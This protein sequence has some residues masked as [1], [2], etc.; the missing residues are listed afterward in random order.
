MLTEDRELSY[1]D[2]QRL[3]SADEIAS[4]FLTLGYNVDARIE[5]T[6]AALGISADSLARRINHIERIADQEEEL[7]AYLLEM[8]SMR[9]ADRQ[10]LAR[11]FRNLSGDFLLILTSDYDTLDFVLLERTLP[12]AGNS[13]MA[14]KRVAVHPH[15]LTV[16][17]QSPD[18]VVLRVLRRFSYTEA[19]PQFQF[20]KLL[21][22]YTV[23]EWSEPLFNNRA[24]FSDYY[25]NQ[26]LRESDEW[27]E[28]PQSMYR[29]LRSLLLD[30]RRRLAGENE[31]TTRTNLLEPAFD[32]LGFAWR[33]CDGRADEPGTPDYRLFGPDATEDDS[34]LALCLAYKWN[35]YLDG[36][37]E[38]RDNDRPD[39]NPGA[40]VVS[41]LE[42][43]QAPYV[44]VTNGKLWRLYA[45]RAH[46]RA[47]N[48]YEVDLEEALSSPDREEAIR[49]FW[50]FF[51]GDA[52]VPRPV[53]H[54]GEMRSL[55]FLDQLVEDSETYAKELGER[56]KDRVFEEIFPHLAEGFI[57]YI[58]REEGSD[59]ELEQDRLDGIY[60]GTLTF[61]YR[62]MFVLYAESRDLLPV[63]DQRGYWEASLSK[64]KGEIA[65][66]AG[67]IVDTAPD[68]VRRAYGADSTMLYEQLSKLFTVIDEGDPN[69]NVPRYNGGLF[70]TVPADDDVSPEA[71]N[72]RFLCGAKIPDRYLALGL[73]LLARDVDAKT[74]ALVMID[75]KTLG[76]RQLG[77]IYEGLLEFKL[78]IARERMAIVKGK[79]TEEIIPYREV[80]KEKRKI[81]TEGRGENRR[82][83]TLA[84]G[85]VYLDNTR[86]ERK[87]TGSY[88]T[89]DYIVKYIVEHTV[90]P[91]LEEKLASLRPRLRELERRYRTH[92]QN[93]IAKS[94]LGRYE[95]P[96]KFWNNGAV[97][98]LAYDVLDIKVL[99]PAMGS[100]HFL[101]ETVDFITDHLLHFLNGFPDNPVRA[102]LERTRQAILGAMEQQQVS[103]GPARLNDVALLK[104]QV[105]KRC[106][107][108]VDLNPMAVE[109]AKVSLWLDA[110]TLGA[111]LSFLDHHLRY[112][113]SL[114]GASARDADR[115]L[116]GETARQATLWGG[117]FEDL[118]RQAEIML[119]IGRL[120]DATMEQVHESANLFRL[121]EEAAKPYKQLLDVFVIRH[122][123]EERAADFL[124]LYGVEVMT[125]DRRNLGK[126][127][128]EVL[129]ERERLFLEHRFFHWDLEFPEVFIDLENRRWWEDAGFDAVVGNP[130]WVNIKQQDPVETRFVKGTL[131]G[132]AGRA[133]SSVMFTA[134]AVDL[135]RKDGLLGFIVSNKFLH[136]QYGKPFL[137]TLQ[138]RAEIE[139]LIDL[140]DSPV[141]EDPTT[142]PSIMSVRNTCRS[143]LSVPTIQVVSVET[144]ERVEM[145]L[146]M[147]DSGSW[148]QSRAAVTGVETSR[149]GLVQRFAGAS[150]AW[151]SLRDL[152]LAIREG[153]ANG[154]D[155]VFLM[156]SEQAAHLR[157]EEEI[158]KPFAFPSDIGR[159]CAQS[160]EHLTIWPYVGRTLIDLERYPQ[161][162][163]YLESHR[164]ELE[165]RYCVRKAG[166]TFYAYHDPAFPTVTQGWKTVTSDIALYPAFSILRGDVVFKNT[167][168]VIVPKPE[169][170]VFFLTAILNSRLTFC[171]LSTMTPRLR[172][173]YLRYKTKYLEALPVPRINFATPSQRRAL[174]ADTTRQLYDQCLYQGHTA[175]L[176]FAEQALSRDEKDTVHDLLAHLAAQMTELNAQTRA[177]VE[178]WISFLEAQI[179]A[180]I[181]DLSGKTIIRRYL[182]D[183]QKG[184]GE[185]PFEELLE[186]LHNNRSQIRANLSHPAFQASLRREYEASLAVLLPVKERLA[187]TDRLI[188]Q[189]VYRLYGLTEEE[190][191]I[192]EGRA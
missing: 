28:N 37:D 102:S 62:M 164:A 172:G 77:S 33:G 57:E 138:E 156:T 121:F 151:Q 188:D 89:P 87:A 63:K 171:N 176:E 39:H 182:G 75:F 170:D 31:A 184:E 30:V 9:V 14:R 119:G 181:H 183:Y 1:S 99:D 192:V 133:D 150:E 126:P 6:P 145:A 69:L 5:Q 187:S 40:R 88:Y 143:A 21:S 191:A 168:Y 17:R 53:V 142:Y 81:L 44:V 106:V 71:A 97:Q 85:A 104:R 161:A 36:R 108:G 146:D 56:L 64:L 51:R 122:F 18:A 153:S 52:F 144:P 116:R 140:S 76:V 166:K 29:A 49:Y 93:A 98:E 4:F 155:T 91:V 70:L 134:R 129:A 43:G 117:P 132:I 54:E 38:T 128:R 8:K 94:K 127:Y 157:L 179:G 27:Q 162:R 47:T 46:S 190:I 103:I 19:D 60:Q 105:L 20:E 90:G 148:K 135:L 12:E 130:P 16:D 123:G 185:L 82:E 112:G 48:Y 136:S 100:G 34:P 175:I 42:S 11:H 80:K 174:M 22:A 78:R 67:D 147:V 120:A 59:V 189:V 10:A 163:R 66:A 83:R 167:M 73:D 24:L 173:G 113:N 55:C 86:Q 7:Q 96:E 149:D 178:R 23:A 131:R 84:K 26:R 15:V 61:L 45:A 79:R 74:Q 186:R 13:G 158:V 3:S 159:Y 68:R 124:R 152:T 139:L 180:K 65:R 115:E 58:R 137:S 25:L 92:R 154:C 141:F 169:V 95:D 107:Y 110:F 114:I 101:V 2:L 165:D 111:P 118:L 50:L 177:G 32:A 41:V 35:R 109:L 125:A 160:P 72:A